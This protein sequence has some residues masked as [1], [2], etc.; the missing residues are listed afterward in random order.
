MP[1]GKDTMTGEGIRLENYSSIQSVQLPVNFLVQKKASDVAY[2]NAGDD[3][4][5][6]FVSA[7]MPHSQL[8]FW[9]RSFDEAILTDLV[10]VLEKPPHTLSDDEY[11]QISPILTP[12]PWSADG[13]HHELS[14]ASLEI[15]SKKA[16][17]YDYFRVRHVANDAPDAVMHPTD[18]RGRAV[19]IPHQTT[20][21]ADI[22]WIRAEAQHFEKMLALFD[23]VLQSVV[24]K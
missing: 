9:H 3:D 24:W 8:G 6:H 21:R 22:L 16:I 18:Y 2:E 10:T 7:D 19:F 5:R 12:G 20:C 13:R 23:Q 4:P 14:L 15:N 17:V 11:F 1:E